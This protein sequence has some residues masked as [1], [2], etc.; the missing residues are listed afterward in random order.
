MSEKLDTEV[1][2]VDYL[3]YKKSGLSVADLDVLKDTVLGV[4]TGNLFKMILAGVKIIVIFAYWY[5]R[6]NL[7]KEEILEKRNRQLQGQVNTD[8]NEADIDTPEI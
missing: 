7:I 6:R 5:L 3:K 4:S 1:T 2:E 8:R